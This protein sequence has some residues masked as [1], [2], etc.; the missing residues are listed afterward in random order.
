MKEGKMLY[1]GVENGRTYASNGR[2]ENVPQ[3]EMVLSQR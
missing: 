3:M 2:R 1:P